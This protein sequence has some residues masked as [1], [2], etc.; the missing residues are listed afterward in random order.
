MLNVEKG[1]PLVN[2]FSIA[3]TVITVIALF[4][5]IRHGKVKV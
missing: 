5:W 3:F 1:I 2:V 4:F